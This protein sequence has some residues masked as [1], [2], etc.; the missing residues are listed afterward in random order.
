MTF[1]VVQMIELNK[2]DGWEFSVAEE[3]TKYAIRRDK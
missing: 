3:G 1:L 2:R